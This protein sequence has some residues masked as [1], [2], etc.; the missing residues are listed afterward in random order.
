MGKSKR[1]NKI[2]GLILGTTLMLAP[3]LSAVAAPAQE[4]EATKAPVSA[5]APS[6]WAGNVLKEWNDKGY[7]KGDQNGSLLPDAKVTRA[8]VAA[9][10]NRSF[11]LT[12]SASVS[13][14]DVKA[15]DWFYADA[16]IAAANGYMKGYTDG[17]FK[18]NANVSRQELAV[19]LNSLL[20]LKA[21]SVGSVQFE[22]TKNSPAWSKGAIETVAAKGLMK[23]NLNKFNPKASATR[24]ETVT[25]LDRALKLQESNNTTTYDKAGEYGPAEGK[26]TIQGNVRVTA[27]GVTLRNLIIEGDLLLGE[28]IGEGDIYLNNV[29]VKGTTTVKGGGK[30][31]IHVEDSVLVTVIVNKKDG[32]VR[33][34]AEGNSIVSQVTLQSGAILQES[35]LVSTAAGFGDVILSDVIPA[36]SGVTLQ[37]KFETIDVVATSLRIDLTAGSIAELAVANTAAGNQINLGPSALIS[38]LILNAATNVG[39]QGSI[40]N[41]QI[42]A[43][44]STLTQRPSST[45]FGN[46]SSAVI[47]GTQTSTSYSGGSNSGSGSGSSNSGGGSNGGSQPA[48]ENQ[49]IVTNGKAVMKFAN[50]EPNL[51]LADLKVSA[52]VS[53]DTY[54]LKNVSFDPIARELTFD[55]LPMN[56][57]YGKS[58][59][60][61]V[62]PA[63]GVTKFSGSLSGSLMLQGFAGRIVDVDDQPVE[64]VTIKFRRGIQNTNGSV[65]A[66]AVT[67]NDGRYMVYLPAGTYNGEL[68]KAGFITSYLVGVSLSEEFNQNENA[69]AIKVPETGELRIVL[70]WGENPTD[71]DSHLVGPTPDGRIFHTWYWDKVHQYDNETYADLDHDD[72]TS[73]GPETTT[74]RKRVDGVYKFY[75]HNFS[76][77]GPDGTNTLR[78]SS[79]KVEVYDQSGVPLKTYHIPVGSGDELYW[80]V[81]DMTVEGNQISF[82][83][84]NILM[85]T[86]PYEEPQED[87]EFPTLMEEFRKIQ[88]VTGVT[89]DTPLG[90]TFSLTYPGE[91]LLA[92]TE[93]TITNV[94]LE[95]PTVTDDVYVEWD[96]NLGELKFAKYNDSGEPVSYVVHYE[97][98]RGDLTLTDEMIISVPTL[99]YLLS[100]AEMEAVNLQRSD[101]TDEI[102]AVHDAQ[103]SGVTTDEK[104]AA[105]QALLAVL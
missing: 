82:A 3:A 12:K 79:A 83:D 72:I 99:N 68:N 40:G 20:G 89:Y 55:P 77:N 16:S 103:L 42:N 61:Q 49:L 66:T 76:E 26:Q 86:P 38:S 10:I 69:T 85:D 104:V 34:V 52:T 43:S 45:T 47:G 56:D 94:T 59:A 101:L 5:E 13:Y 64:G 81:F 28:E 78:N 98:S 73:Y 41:A 100:V 44:G 91:V 4:A 2:L 22:D 96:Q 32:S 75:V 65:V 80:Y 36:E 39:G 57:Y 27:A 17:S 50:S 84:Q 87:P 31:S 63:D 23:G 105:L 53:G 51:T 29:N 6:H 14:T 102:Q 48:T 1:F 67:D 19:I 46:N 37:G 70:T 35:G 54:E 15:N 95:D 58:L 62:S 93:L 30:N 90:S 60:L 18:P 21:S 74:I 7:I 92:D 88:S 9:L 25:V 8:Q 97:L 33:I 71:E 11:G 24:A